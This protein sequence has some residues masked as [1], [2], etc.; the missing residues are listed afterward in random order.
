MK[1]FL[2]E[3]AL[4]ILAAICV[5]VSVMITVPTTGGIEDLE[6]FAL[7]N[8]IGLEEKSPDV[9]R[10]VETSI[11]NLNTMIRIDASMYKSITIYKVEQTSNNAT[12]YISRNSQAPT[13]A[14]FGKKY[15]FEKNE[16]FDFFVYD[17]SLS[18][19]E[20]VYIQYTLSER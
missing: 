11:N 13:I 15:R 14:E 17:T 9:T 8:A 6:I 5:A 3:Y 20:P 10:K 16:E 19:D 2:E 12:L 4:S 1:D 7:K 18:I